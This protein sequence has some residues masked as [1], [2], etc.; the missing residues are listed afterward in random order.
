[1]TIWI[2]IASFFLVLALISLINY[3]LNKEF[4]IETPWLALSL[5]PVVMWLLTTQQ[6]SELS[7]FG[8]AFKLKEVTSSAVSL[9]HDGTTIKP[10]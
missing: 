2:L 9:Q 1:M 6:L 4:K 10:P 7:G 3:K 5:A 8:L